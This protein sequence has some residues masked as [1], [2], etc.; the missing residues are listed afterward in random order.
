MVFGR[1]RKARGRVQLLVAEVLRDTG[2]TT[3]LFVLSPNAQKVE[4]R[5]PGEGAQ[6]REFEQVLAKRLSHTLPGT[7]LIVVP[8]RENLDHLAGAV[9]VWGRLYGDVYVARGGVE[10]AA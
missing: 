4:V 9:S 2:Q 6:L 7:K 1:H 10:N 8:L 3:F 5:I